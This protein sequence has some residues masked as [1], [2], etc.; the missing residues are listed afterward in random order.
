MWLV[1]LT[2]K[3]S[4]IAAF[5]IQFMLITSHSFYELYSQKKTIVYLWRVARHKCTWFGR[6]ETE[7]LADLNQS[8]TEENSWL[9][10]KLLFRE[11]VFNKTGEENSLYTE[12]IKGYQFKFCNIKRRNVKYTEGKISLFWILHWR[13]DDAPLH[14]TNQI[15]SVRCLLQK[16]SSCD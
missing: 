15:R 7:R 6:K 3:S 12:N 8:S 5:N 9:I 13:K 4:I 10:G 16:T 1:I 14:I 2:V 11:Q